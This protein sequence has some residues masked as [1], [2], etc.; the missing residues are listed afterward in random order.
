VTALAT[1]R[2]RRLSAQCVS[3]PKDTIERAASV[4]LGVQA[5]DLRQARFALALRTVGASRDDVDVAFAK[6]QI[7][8]TWAMRGTIHVVAARDLRWTTRLLGPRNMARAARHLRDLAIDADAVSCARKI[9]ESALPGKTMTRSELFERFERAQQPVR[10]QRGTLLLFALTQ[11]GVLCQAG[12]AFAL[13]DDWIPKGDGPSG[14]EALAE[15]A[16]R[17]E[18]GH[19]PATAEDLA[20]W[21]GIGKREATRAQALAKPRGPG[22]KPEAPLPAATLLPGFDEYLLGYADR[23]AILAPEH[24]PRVVPGGNG[25][26]LPMVVVRGV[27]VGT[28]QPEEAAGGTTLV[29]HP[30]VR[31]SREWRSAL[32]HAAERYRTYSGALASVRVAPWVPP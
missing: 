27:V 11:A 4:M 20:F 13:T 7:V 29:V 19:G 24:A 2:A 30:F 25:I 18:I 21:A 15:L 16:R 26:Y 32:D 5:Q 12:E 1:L 3:C 31:P 6:K 23:S 17:Y 8:R 14:D 10:G 22:P 9:V 28:W